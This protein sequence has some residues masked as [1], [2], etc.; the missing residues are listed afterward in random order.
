MG[1]SVAFHLVPLACISVFAP[2]PYCLDDHSS[3]VSL[4]SGRLIPLALCLSQDCFGSSG[5]LCFHM[6]CETFCSSLVKNSIG[7]PIQMALDLQIIFGSIVFFT[8]LILP[9]QE[10]GIA[11]HLFMLS[12]ISFLKVLYFSVYS[13]YV[14]LAGFFPWHFIL[15]VAMV[16]GIDTLIS[17]SVVSLIVQSNANDF[18]VLF[19]YV[20]L[21]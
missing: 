20:S 19:L 8:V 10:H 21:C 18:C 16:T 11:L 3:A 17:L 7:D 1:L 14:S 4:K 5:L 6:S 12:L 9:T 2:A 13:S 15:F